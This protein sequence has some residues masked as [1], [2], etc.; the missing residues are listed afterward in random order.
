MFYYTLGILTGMAGIH[1]NNFLLGMIGVAIS[2]YAAITMLQPK[3]K[4]E[5]NER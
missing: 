3:E 4:E 1:L 5:T 2:T